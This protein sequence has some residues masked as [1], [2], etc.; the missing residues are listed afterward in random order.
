MF[1]IYALFLWFVR[2]NGLVLVTN[3]LQYLNYCQPIS[4]RSTC[5]WRRTSSSNLEI[6]FRDWGM[7]TRMWGGAQEVTWLWKVDVEGG[8]P[9]AAVPTTKNNIMKTHYAVPRYHIFRTSIR[10]SPSELKNYLKKILMAICS[11]QA[12]LITQKKYRN[13]IR[14]C[15][16]C[17]WSDELIFILFIVYKHTFVRCS[18]IYVHYKLFCYHLQLRELIIIK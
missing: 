13:K 1:R 14:N 17:V 2:C 15:L 11:V 18:F 8:V 4:R 5:W 7:Y 9:T 6:E 16:D 3:P 10:L 12:S